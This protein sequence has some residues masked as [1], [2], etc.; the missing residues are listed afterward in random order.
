M[1]DNLNNKIWLI[2]S[3]PMAVDYAKVLCAMNFPFSVIGRGETS[4]KAFYDKTGVEVITGGLEKALGK[5]AKPHSAI[6]STGIDE[7]ASSAQLLMDYG[8]NKILLEKPGIAEPSEINSLVEKSKQTNS[9]VV[10]AYNRRFY[11]S[12]RKAKEII[13]QDGGVVSFNFEFTEWSHEIKNIKKSDII[14]HHWFLGNSSHVVDLAFYLGGRPKEIS[15]FVKGGIDWHPSSSV[16]AGAGIS[17]TGALFSYQ[18]NW[19]APGRWSVEMLT[20][21]H[22]LIF[23]PMEKLQIQKIGSVAID[24]VADIDYTLDET[25]KPGLYLELNSFLKNDYTVFSTIQDQEKFMKQFY[26]EMAGYKQLENQ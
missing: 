3:G 16:F 21:K 25:Y 6:V 22:R 26:L 19:E 4:A 20:S 8:V 11:A 24:M 1:S 7:L 2:G 12:V 18:A 13:K 14:M 15:S 17:E 23:R 10:L 9:T 5:F